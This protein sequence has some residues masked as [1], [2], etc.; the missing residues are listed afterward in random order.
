MY[1]Y[2][3]VALLVVIPFSGDQSWGA[4]VQE[5]PPNLASN[6]FPLIHFYPGTATLT[7]ENTQ[8]LQQVARVLLNRYLAGIVRV[9]GRTDGIENSPQGPMPKGRTA[10]SWARAEIVRDYLVSQGVPSARLQVKGQGKKH[11]L[12]DLKTEE[13]RV[14]NRSV[15]LVLTPGSEAGTAPLLPATPVPTPISTRTLTETPRA[16]PPPIPTKTSAPI[17]TKTSAPIPTKGSVS[18]PTPALD[19]QSRP[20]PAAPVSKHT[21]TV[22]IRSN[23]TSPLE[24]P[25]SAPTAWTEVAH[26]PPPVLETDEYIASPINKQSDVP[27]GVATVQLE[28]K[29]LRRV[30]PGA[31]GKRL[32]PIREYLQPQLEGIEEL[33]RKGLK[34]HHDLA[35]ITRVT[36][37]LNGSGVVQRV[38]VQLPVPHSEFQET[39]TEFMLELEFPPPPGEDMMEVEI[40]Y[41]V[42]ATFRP[43]VIPLR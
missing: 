16:T 38:V 7:D 39:A 9:E 15:A 35:G 18:T 1:L 28:V 6:P 41:G 36:Y 21:K 40:E 25:S 29:V 3:V 2:P 11:P 42:F 12:G 8:A 34:E 19:G 23:A 14:R 22:Y 27:M 32:W 20:P 30:G 33:F 43:L 37:W 26:A 17:P 24:M 10:L 4:D 13:D 5:A 31:S